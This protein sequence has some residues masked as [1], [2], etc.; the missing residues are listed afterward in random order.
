MTYVLYVVTS[1]TGLDAIL[2]SR[3]KVRCVTSAFLSLW[4]VHLTCLFCIR[5]QLTKHRRKH[6]GERPFKCDWPGCTYDC[7]MSSAMRHNCFPFSVVCSFHMFVLHSRPIDHTLSQAY[8]GEALQVRLDWMQVCFHA[9]RSD[10]SHLL[11]FLCE[12]VHLTC[13]FCIRGNLVVHRRKH[14]GEK[15]FKCDWIGCTSAFTTSSPMRH[16]CFP[17]SANLFI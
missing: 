11:S 4:F 17:F 10:A 5:G 1:A 9:V 3:R 16:I 14:T 7:T 6:T 15:P 13:L 8:R 12:F 2:L